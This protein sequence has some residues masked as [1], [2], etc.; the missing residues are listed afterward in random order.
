MFNMAA[1]AMGGGGMALAGMAAPMA[2][3]VPEMAAADNAMVRN[4]GPALKKSAAAAKPK[5]KEVTKV[6]TEF[7]ESWIW[8]EMNSKYE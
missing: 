6:R 7:P 1:P 3:A 2:R 8:A 4:A 5:L